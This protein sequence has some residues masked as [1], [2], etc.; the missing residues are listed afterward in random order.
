MPKV[1][2]FEIPADKPHRAVKFYEE[3]FG[4]DVD[5]WGGPFEYWLAITGDDKL[6]GID[7]A[8]MERGEESGVRITIDVPSLDEFSI[9]IIDAGGKLLQPKATIPGV[10]HI[11]MFRDTEGNHFLIMQRDEKAR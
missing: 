2:H 7:G 4:W 6:P 10:G 3:V 8:I 11:A 9:K 5:K 1:I